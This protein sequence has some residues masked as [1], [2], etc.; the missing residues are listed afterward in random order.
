MGAALVDGP[1]P[2]VLESKS[3]RGY[4][5]PEGGR[6]RGVEAPGLTGSSALE[7]VVGKQNS[8]RAVSAPLV[9][10]AATG[11]GR[12]PDSLSLQGRAKRRIVVPARAS[13]WGTDGREDLK[14]AEPRRG[15]R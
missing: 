8:R 15:G 7:R 11:A 5:N 3:S 2:G 6:C 13:V 10:S 9:A 14:G 1:W 12:G 4:P